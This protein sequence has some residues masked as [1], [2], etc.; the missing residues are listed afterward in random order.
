MTKQY[1]VIDRQQDGG[2]EDGG[3]VVQVAQVLR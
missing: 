3:A 2:D 1:K